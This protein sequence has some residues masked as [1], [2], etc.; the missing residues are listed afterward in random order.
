[1]C[2]D[3]SGRVFISIYSITVQ[4]IIWTAIVLTSSK[5]LIRSSFQS[6]AP[7]RS[8]WSSEH[9]GQARKES[10]LSK[11]HVHVHVHFST[12]IDDSIIHTYMYMYMN[13]NVK[14]LY[15]LGIF[16]TLRASGCVRPAGRGTPLGPSPLL[17]VFQPWWHHDALHQLQDQSC[18]HLDRLTVG[19]PAGTATQSNHHSSHN[20]LASG[21]AVHVYSTFLRL[22]GCCF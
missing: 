10:C 21:E 20:V 19:Q 13:R 3:S 8:C 6:L 12:V 9:Q 1:M 4:G 15:L 18:H 14:V 7:A 22:S 5:M 16:P 11:L 2:N 17:P